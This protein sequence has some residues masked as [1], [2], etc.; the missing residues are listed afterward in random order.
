MSQSQTTD[1]ESQSNSLLLGTCSLCGYQGIFTFKNDRSVR[2]DYCCASCRADVR[3][4]DLGAVILDEF[5]RGLFTALVR[6]VRDERF[7]KTK[8]LESSLRGQFVKYL[9]KLPNYTQSYYWPDVPGGESRNGIECQD[10]RRLTFEDNT[11]DLVLTSDVFEHVFE[12]ERAFTEILRVLRPG[13][14]HI[15]SIPFHWPVAPRSQTR[16]IE[17]GGRT[18]HLLSPQ[19]HVAGD[20]TDSLVVTD[21]GADLVD[22]LED[23]GYRVSVVRR[24]GPLF[25]L[26]TN[27]TFVARK[28]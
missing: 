11:F 4:R 7:K 21:W 10:L 26:H 16:S 9:K 1:F 20:G 15:F 23:I 19:Y 28:P 22:K 6:L 5:G 13:G 25:P 12:P 24:S 18:K 14:M 8:I 17:S 27:A 2:G 3:H